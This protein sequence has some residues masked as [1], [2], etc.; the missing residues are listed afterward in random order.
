MIKER[1]QLRVE[2]LNDIWMTLNNQLGAIVATVLGGLILIGLA[3]LARWKG[4]AAV[5]Q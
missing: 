2:F 4:W 1:E 5:R 3:F